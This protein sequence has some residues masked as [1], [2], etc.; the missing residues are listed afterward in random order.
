MAKNKYQ[1]MANGGRIKNHGGS[2][3]FIVACLKKRCA[4]MKNIA[5]HFL[6]V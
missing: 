4:Q 1:G 2:F 3:I 6:K 5:T